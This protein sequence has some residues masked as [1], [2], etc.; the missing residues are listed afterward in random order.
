MPRF[1]AGGEILAIGDYD[2]LIC[3]V[4]AT[5]AM[6]HDH[7]GTDLSPFWRNTGTTLE[8]DGEATPYLLLRN[9]P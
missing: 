7:S 1:E 2:L 6:P 4:F 5:A 9:S 3:P 8:V